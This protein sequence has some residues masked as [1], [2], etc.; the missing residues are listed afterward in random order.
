MQLFLIA[1]L[2]GKLLKKKDFFCK[3]FAILQTI[4]L[5][6]QSVRTKP[7]NFNLGLQVL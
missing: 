2:L 7:C 6:I 3:A 1:F 5:S 4:N